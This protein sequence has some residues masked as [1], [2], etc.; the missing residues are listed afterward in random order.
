MKEKKQSMRGKLSPRNPKPY[1]TGR[2]PTTLK[3]L[4]KDW[5]EIMTNCA[6][7]GG[8][9]TSFMVNLKIGR[10]ALETLLTNEEEFRHTYEQCG[11]LSQEW[12][13]KKGREM[14]CGERG[15]APVWSM[16][17]ANKYGWKSSKN[18]MSGDQD[19]PIR[20]KISNDDMSDDELKLELESRGLPTTLFE[21]N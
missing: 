2:P 12:Y 8:G 5:K 9:S 18:E 7:E 11:L 20:H 3:D 13:E 19:N 15:S 10:S 16:T 17:M 4:P 14:I 21:D 1:K 6:M